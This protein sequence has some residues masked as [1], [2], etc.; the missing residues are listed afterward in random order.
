[1]IKRND[2]WG[3]ASLDSGEIIIP[4]YQELKL[5][6]EEMAAF[7]LNDLYGFLDIN[8]V[9]VIS[10]LYDEVTSFKMAVAF[11]KQD[12]KWG[13]ID[14]VGNKILEPLTIGPFELYMMYQAVRLRVS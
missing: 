13:L 1:L 5:F 4:I 3:F 14:R 12:G 2:R 10:P 8:G 9:E 6:S 7:K 11:F